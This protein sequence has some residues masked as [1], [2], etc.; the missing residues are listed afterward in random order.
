MDQAARL[1]G[2]ELSLDWAVRTQKGC[3]L[4]FVKTS[5]EGSP[6]AGAG[7]EENN[8]IVFLSYRYSFEVAFDTNDN[9]VRGAVGT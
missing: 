3:L 2:T 7:H 4:M 9:S 1:P 6:S 5:L 8:C